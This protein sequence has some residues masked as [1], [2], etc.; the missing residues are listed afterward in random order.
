[1]EVL[2]AIL[3]QVRNKSSAS[4]Y[5]KATARITV[6]VIPRSSRSEIVGA[7]DGTVKVKLTSPPVDGAANA[8][9]LSLLAKRLGV[10]RSSVEI[11]G[12][13]SS[14]T[15]HV[16]IAGLTEEEVYEMLGK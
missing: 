8:E 10:A 12:G 6:K 4:D 16:R 5:E 15:K 14:R 3:P 11:T 2:P 7:F 9:L 13:L 1:M